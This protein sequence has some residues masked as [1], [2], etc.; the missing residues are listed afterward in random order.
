MLMREHILPQRCILSES[1]LPANTSLHSPTHQQRYAAILHG[2]HRPCPD[3]HV[4]LRGP[5]QCISDAPVRRLCR[6][7]LFG[8]ISSI[9]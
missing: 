9:L 6:Q 5:V 7:L 4:E 8:E 1:P 3:L 2:H